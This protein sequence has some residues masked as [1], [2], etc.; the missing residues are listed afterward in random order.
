VGTFPSASIAWQ[1]DRHFNLTLN[2]V[3]YLLGDF[4]TQS[5]PGQ[6]NGNYVSA[7]ATFKF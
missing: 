7:V 6:E 4:V 5:V 2:Y 3:A 1:I